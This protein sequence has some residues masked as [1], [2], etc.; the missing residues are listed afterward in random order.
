MVICYSSDRTLIH[1]LI[2]GG[3]VLLQEICKNDWNL[4]FGRC[5]Q[6]FNKNDRNSLDYL[7]RFLA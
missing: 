5:L 4:V 6:N 1:I 2:P 7:E 3:S